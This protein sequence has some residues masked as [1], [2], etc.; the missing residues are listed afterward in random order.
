MASPGS[1]YLYGSPS[2]LLKTSRQARAARATACGTRS[3]EMAGGG[4][5]EPA[6]GERFPRG[7]AG[8]ASR[9]LRMEEH[10]RQRKA[11]AGGPISEPRPAEEAAEDHPN[12]WLSRSTGFQP[13]KW[14][15]PVT[16]E[17]R[18]SR[19]QCSA[20]SG[21]G[22]KARLSTARRLSRYLRQKGGE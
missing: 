7:S 9:A 14:P 10:F 4:G 8:P 18:P 3:L 1:S 16:T 22:W 20:P 15:D 21:R 11:L 2:H 13:A 17:W 19:R 6:R 5:P 12:D